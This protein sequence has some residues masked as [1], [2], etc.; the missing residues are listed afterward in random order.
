MIIIILI[1]VDYKYNSY[2][3]HNYA[4]GW[5]TCNKAVRTLC[6][7]NI[8]NS[9]NNYNLTTKGITDQY[10]NVRTYTRDHQ[11]QQRRPAWPYH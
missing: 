5:R 8:S 7:R 3:I 1:T 9:N 2:F 11:D 4:Y 6:N 10:S